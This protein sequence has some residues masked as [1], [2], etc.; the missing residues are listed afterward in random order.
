M[1]RT[2]SSSTRSRATILVPVGPCPAESSGCLLGGHRPYRPRRTAGRPPSRRNGHGGREEHAA[3]RLAVARGLWR[4]GTAIAGTPAE[5][6][7]R[8]ARGYSGPLPATL[9]YP[10]PNKPE[11]HPAMVAAFG[12]ARETEPGVVEI[13]QA[14]VTGV[15]LTLISPDG[16]TKAGT[17]TGQAHDR[18]ELG[19]AN[20]NRSTE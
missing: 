19:F 16:S 8:V 17:V 6:Y 3:E 12:T 14:E 13:N 11:H 20:R 1:H 10:R 5:R 15:A 9:R 18:P 2:A 7:L 4:R